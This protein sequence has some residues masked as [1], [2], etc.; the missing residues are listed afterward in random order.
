MQTQNSTLT[1]QNV[2]AI[3]PA[4]SRTKSGFLTRCVIHAPD[5]NPSLAVDST[6]DGKA[7]LVC[8]A[9][10][11]QDSLIERVKELI[12]EAK[13][14]PD[15]TPS[16]VEPAQSTADVSFDSLTAGLDLAR[17]VDELVDSDSPDP[18]SESAGMTFLTQRGISEAVAKQMQLGYDPSTSSIAI[19][20]YWK[21]ELIGVKFRRFA[22]VT[23]INKWRQLPGSATDILMFSQATPIDERRVAVVVESPLDG[24]LVWSEG[25]NTIA[26]HSAV[27]PKTDR[28]REGLDIAKA[29]F[30]KFVL[31]GDN[32]IPGMKAMDRMAEL[33]GPERCTRRP[34]PKGKDITD[35]FQEDAEACRQWL[36]QQVDEAVS[37]IAD[38]FETLSPDP[39][40]HGYKLN[41]PT[42]DGIEEESIKWLWDGFL[43]EKLTVLA[44]APGTGKSTLAYTFAA[45]VSNGGEWPDGSKAKAGRVL[46]WSAED[47]TPDIVLPRL[48]AAGANLGKVHV[49]ESVDY[50]NGERRAF[51]PASD[52]PKVRDFVLSHRDVR[53]LIVDP[54]VSA[55]Q[56]DM[57]KS[58]EVRRGL[59][60]LVDFAG[61][62]G[63]SVIGINHF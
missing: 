38:P 32:D 15:F 14:D 53:L 33:L 50:D 16:P 5:R 58:N 26:L 62:F 59:Q 29:K 42:L 12:H 44:G 41:A 60:S 34:V 51:D 61:E 37:S 17:Y 7:L 25:F 3:F 63:I 4:T 23:P 49:L 11:N 24:A 21:G 20:S 39:I 45:I 28:F 57:N 47:T 6:A 22:G 27:I 36:R 1:F 10:C 18:F 40:S 46:L 19:P 8:R 55:I 2:A 56:G 35:C 43:P 13:N 52:I 48:K 30:D 9:G 31:I 54:I